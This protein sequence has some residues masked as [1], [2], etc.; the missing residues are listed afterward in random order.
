VTAKALAAYP[1]SILGMMQ[2]M[3]NAFTAIIEQDE[4]WFIA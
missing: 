2:S 1:G 4:G 3:R